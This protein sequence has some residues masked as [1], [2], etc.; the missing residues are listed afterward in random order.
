MTR[1]PEADEYLQAVMEMSEAFLARV[2][3]GHT[4]SRRRIESAPNLW[5]VRAI[6][7]GESEPAVWLLLEPDHSVHISVGGRD[8]VENSRE[9]PVEEMC[10]WIETM[11]ARGLGF[12]I[13]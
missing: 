6:A 2:L 1:I 7:L 12:D 3:P 4:V 8:S 9:Q 11:I 10:L 13:S 5:E